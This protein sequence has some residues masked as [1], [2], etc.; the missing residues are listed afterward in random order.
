MGFTQ[1]TQPKHS[2]DKTLHIVSRGKSGGV[3]EASGKLL[4]RALFRSNE[5]VEGEILK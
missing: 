1:V 4:P 5:V 2:L 3:T